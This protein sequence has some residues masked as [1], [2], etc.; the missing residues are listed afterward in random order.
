M[1][2]LTTTSGCLLAAR[3]LNGS[4]PWSLGMGAPKVLGLIARGPYLEARLAL[5]KGEIDF[6]FPT[7]EACRRV[8]RIGAIPA[9][10]KA[11]VF[12]RMSLGKDRCN[13][14]G[15]L[16]LAH[17]HDRTVRQAGG[18]APTGIAYFQEQWRDEEYIFVRGRFPLLNRMGVA[19]DDLIVALPNVGLC[20]LPVQR[21]QATI[22]YASTGPT[23]YRLIAG[24]GQCVLA[25]LA[26]PLT[27][28][29]PQP[30]PAL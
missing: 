21:G 15:T 14:V 17:W 10:S 12:G 16:S 9:Y 23:P 28:P 3:D 29:P 19:S 27:G 24:K 8:L 1:L 25:G 2:L 6:L 11:G 4:P 7:T 30:R 5:R 13:A 20:Q 18:P 26:I 22:Q